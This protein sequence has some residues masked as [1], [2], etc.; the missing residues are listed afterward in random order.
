MA[1][2]GHGHSQERLMFRILMVCLISITIGA[3]ASTSPEASD[4]PA[5]TGTTASESSGSVTSDN[6]AGQPLEEGTPELDSSELPQTAS[7]DPDYDPNELI[8][9]RERQTGSK[10]TV[11]TC[12]T[13]AEIDAR[14]EQ[15]QEIMEA[16]QRKRMCTVASQGC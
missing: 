9:K 1:I 10:F 4:A 7:A 3:C 15:D 12:Q 8:C 13:R 6:P 5:P 14:A 2:E 16:Y 11:R